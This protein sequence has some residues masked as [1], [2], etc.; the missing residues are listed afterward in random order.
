MIIVDKHYLTTGVNEQSPVSEGG[1]VIIGED[2][3]SHALKWG[4][5]VWLELCEPRGKRGWRG[6]GRGH[7]S[8]S[9]FYCVTWIEEGNHGWVDSR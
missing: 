8:I 6:N 1:P 4:R 3:M 9:G 5:P 7:V 2:T